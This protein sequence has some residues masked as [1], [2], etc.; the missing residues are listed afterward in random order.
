MKNSVGEI[1]RKKMEELRLVCDREIPIQQQKIDAAT[2]SFKKSLDST[3][4][5]AQETLQFHAKLGKLKVELRELEDKLVKALAVKTRKEAKQIAVADSISAAKDRVEELR[6]VVKNQRA[7]KD[8]YAAIISK[9]TDELKA[10]EEKHNQTAEQREEIEEAIVW[11]NKVLGLHIECGHGVKFI[12]T[13][14]DANNQDKEYIFTVRHENDVYTLIDC[15]PQ[16]NDAKELLRELNTSNGLFKFVRTM[17]EKFQAAITHG[18]FPDIASH[19]Q[20]TF[21]ISVSAPVSFNSTDSRSEF[22]SQQQ[23]HQSDEHNRN[24]KKLDH[25]KGSRAAVLSP[26][27]ASSLR[28]SPRFKVKR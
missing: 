3:K 26:G 27:S 25:A 14:I 17:R 15:D 22:L 23:E 5:Q 9:Q 28:R 7:S 13:N 18:T 4:V 10:C 19:D 6:V 16:L 11:Y 21:M 24:S 2:R 12:F 8:E 20:D 1:T